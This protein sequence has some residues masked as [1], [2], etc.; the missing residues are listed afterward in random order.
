M[1]ILSSK[2]FLITLGILAT[3]AIAWFM[4]SLSIAPLALL[5][6]V[7]PGGISAAEQ[8]KALRESRADKIKAMDAL[9]DKET[10]EKRALNVDESKQYDTL[11]MEVEGINQRIARL[12]EKEARDA[13]DA[14]ASGVHLG[15][16]ANRHESEKDRKDIRKFSWHKL[17]RSQISDY[18]TRLDGIEAEMSQEGHK[19]AADAGVTPLGVAVSSR[20][21]KPKA[22]EQRDLTVGSAASAGNI[23]QTQLIDFVP[24]LRPALFSE[25]LGARMLTGL[26]GNV[27]ISRKTGEL[28]ASWAATE[29]AAASESQ[30]TTDKISLTPKRLAATVDISKQLLAQGSYDAQ[31]LTIEDMNAQI[32]IAVDK[33]FINGAGA[34]GEPQGL[35]QDSGVSVLALGTNGLAPTR[36]HLVDLEALIATNNAETDNMAFLTTP[37]ARAFFK[38][39]KTDAGS[40]IF[41]W[42]MLN[43]LLGY[44][45]FATNQVPT[46]LVKGASG[47]VCDAIILGDFSAAVI[48]NWAGID[49]VI[50]PYSRKK[51]AIIEVT[52][53]SWWDIN[54]RYPK[55]F[56]VIKDAIV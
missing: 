9:I 18:N 24:A 21:W 28:T 15:S 47:A 2:S 25:R 44:R 19:E 22:K 17:I 40:G 14:I 38:K 54:R 13:A 5:G 11:K 42:D 48:A 41:V 52:I 3:I 35:L 16:E 55:M 37:A 32:K 12:Q 34:S 23:V 36:D 27:D 7:L 49:L 4:P 6:Q 10:T 29:N 20:L 39:L 1:K 50:D 53:N 31:A 43:E 8:I 45:A 56:A 33:A 51:E 26:V 30:W 46:N